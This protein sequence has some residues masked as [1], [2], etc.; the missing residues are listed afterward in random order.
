VKLAIITTALM[1][2]TWNSEAAGAQD[3][4]HLLEDCTSPG[5]SDA[6]TAC[7]AY[8]AGVRDTV[9]VTQLAFAPRRCIP[10]AATTGQVRDV[11]VRH[12]RQN[13]EARHLVAAALIIRAMREAWCPDDPLVDT[14]SVNYPGA[15]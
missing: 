11:V 3:G 12:L 9:D 14:P 6:L 10:Q 4:N 15:R 7:V 8:L 1:L 13:P 2:S 5:G